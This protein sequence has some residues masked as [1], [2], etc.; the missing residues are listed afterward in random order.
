MNINSRFSHSNLNPL[1]YE[2]LSLC[3]ELVKVG[4]GVN[5]AP[6]M[7]VSSEQKALCFSNL[8]KSSNSSI[9][10]V[11]KEERILRNLLRH[12]DSPL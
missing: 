4:L 9:W 10:S 3:V 12:S 5:L 11:A 1:L 7:A 2:T 6:K 8:L